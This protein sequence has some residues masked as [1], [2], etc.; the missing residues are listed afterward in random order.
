MKLSILYE[1]NHLLIINK[2]AGLATMG[3]AADVPSLL[4][5]AKAYIKRKYQKPGN[6]YL[7]IVSRLDAPV[8][9]AVVVTTPQDVAFADVRRAIKSFAMTQTH[10]LG[11]VENMSFFV[12][13]ECQ[14]EHRLFGESRIDQHAE[15]LGFPV[16]G[17]LPLDSVTAVAAD[18]GEPIVI[19][20]PESPVARGFRELAGKVAQH[21]AILS[22]DQPQE[23]QFGDFFA[24]KKG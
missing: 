8:T 3:V 14:T 13:G 24:M 10:V 9:G 18:Q 21:V 1:D 5:E 2:P 4:T 23:Q 6:V 12:C 16:L 22:Q 17:K 7:G 20:A 15:S 11:L 19:A